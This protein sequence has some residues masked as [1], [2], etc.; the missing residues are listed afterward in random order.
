MLRKFWEVEERHDQTSLTPEERTVVQHFKENHSCTPNGQFI[1]PLPKQQHTKPLRES[2]SQA[3][4]RFLALERSLY[5]KGQ[6][7]DFNAMI[8]EY[9]QMGHAE[10]VPMNDSEKQTSK[11]SI[12]QC[13]LWEKSLALK[14]NAE[15]D[16]FCLTIAKL[17][18]LE[19][20]TKRILVFWH[21]QDIQC[22]WV[23]F[24]LHHQSRFS[25]SNFGHL[26]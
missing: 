5:S 10:L 11:C 18:P 22:A 16:H 20:V 19:D 17:P 9:F 25:Y 4:R 24:S 14:W 26:N 15:A 12:Y 23:V 3:V 21:C 8:T 7:N 1:V 2:R 13:M 6:F